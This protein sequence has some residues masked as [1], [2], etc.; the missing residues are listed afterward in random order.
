MARQTASSP[1]IGPSPSGFQP[2]DWSFSQWISA[3]GL[4]TNPMSVVT[5]LPQNDSSESLTNLLTLAT[6]QHPDVVKVIS[7]FASDVSACFGTKITKL[8][9]H[10]GGVLHGDT[11][12]CELSNDGYIFEMFDDYRGKRVMRNKVTI[13]IET[14]PQLSDQTSKDTQDNQGFQ[15]IKDGQEDRYIQ[16]MRDFIVSNDGKE[17]FILQFKS[18]DVLVY[19]SN[20]AFLRCITLPRRRLAC[21]NPYIEQIEMNKC[22]QLVMLCADEEDNDD[23]YDEMTFKLIY[24]VLSTS[25]ELISKV[26]LDI[27]DH[28]L[29]RLTKFIVS[30][31]I[32]N[33]LIFVG[34]TQHNAIHAFDAASGKCMRK[35]HGDVFFTSLP[36][37]NLMEGNF[38]YTVDEPGCE[39]VYTRGLIV[40]YDGTI[41]HEIGQHTFVFDPRPVV[42]MTGEIICFKNNHFLF[43]NTKGKFLRKI[44]WDDHDVFSFKLDHRGRLIISGHYGVWCME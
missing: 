19:S 24:A 32:I 3:R 36:K 5:V 6:Q 21:I 14:P 10:L 18:T 35:M 17:I 40:N 23:R 12:K 9:E 11:R 41:Q 28:L 43:Y 22:G 2:V 39:H 37:I 29:K 27:S 20:G 4:Y 25:G 1:W 42:L 33:G 31:E 16:H 13:H 30:P 15:N 26:S 7:S 38:D 8:Y 34:I 44:Q